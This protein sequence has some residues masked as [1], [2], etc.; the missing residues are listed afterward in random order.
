M[1]FPEH[2]CTLAK[3]LKHPSLEFLDRPTKLCP[4]L[5]CLKVGMTEAIFRLGLQSTM[6]PKKPQPQTPNPRK[7]TAGCTFLAQAA[8]VSD[9]LPGKE[10]VANPSRPDVSA[11]GLYLEKPMYLKHV[12]CIWHLISLPH[13]C[14]F[15]GI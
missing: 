2:F 9:P 15:Q 1:T 14:L 7:Q 5:Q 13:L 3:I 6:T 4:V 11:S 8:R 12:L 10:P